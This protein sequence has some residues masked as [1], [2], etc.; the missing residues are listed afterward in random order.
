MRLFIIN[1]PA[2]VSTDSTAC[3]F[4]MKFKIWTSIKSIVIG[5]IKVVASFIF[6]FI[7][8]NFM[9]P[10]QLSFVLRSL[11]KY[12]MYEM[13]RFMYINYFIYKFSWFYT[14]RIFFLFKECLALDTL[15]WYSCSI[16]GRDTL[17]RYYWN[18]IK[19]DKNKI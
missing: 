14:W 17:A 13:W 18:V 3:K 15:A 19:K 16:L 9:E 8:S 11:T 2:T 4:P 6:S 12:V 7:G 1:F 10:F 5:W